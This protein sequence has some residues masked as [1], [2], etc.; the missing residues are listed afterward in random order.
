MARI[1]HSRP[2]KERVRAGNESRARL[3]KPAA[4]EVKEG[5]TAQKRSNCLVIA[6]ADA[7][8]AAREARRRRIAEA[9]RR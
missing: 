1:V 2:Q 3:A 5:N 8:L 6:F 4:A 9:K 7:R